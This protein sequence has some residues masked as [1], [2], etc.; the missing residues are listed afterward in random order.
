[1]TGVIQGYF[2]CDPLPNLPEVIYPSSQVWVSTRYISSMTLKNDQKQYFV[3]L[4][5]HKPAVF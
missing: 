2:G 3:H 4:F 5:Q 1:M